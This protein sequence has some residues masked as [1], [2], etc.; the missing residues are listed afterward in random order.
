MQ[1]KRS[2]SCFMNSPESHDSVFNHNNYPNNDENIEYGYRYRY[3]DL[4]Y[5]NNHQNITSEN[6]DKN[7]FFTENN[8]KN[9]ERF[10]ILKPNIFYTHKKSVF[11][12]VIRKNQATFKN[13]SHNSDYLQ[14]NND[15]EKKKLSSKDINRLLNI[16]IKLDSSKLTKN[17]D[18]AI[19]K[20]NEILKKGDFTIKKLFNVETFLLKFLKGEEINND[21]ISELN[22]IEKVLITAFLVKKK[23]LDVDF[24]EFNTKSI[25]FIQERGCHKRSEQEY[26]T[27]LKKAFKQMI[28]IFNQK[29]LIF[30][31]NKKHFYKHYFGEI[32][33][34]LNIPI[35]N[36][37]LEYLFNE[38]KNQSKKRKS[39]KNYA[40]ILKTSSKFMNDLNDYLDNSF[41]YNGKN[42]GSIDDATKDIN[43][44][45]PGIVMKWKNDLM[46][47][48]D[49]D[50]ISKFL[51]EFFKNKKIKL[52]WSFTEISKAIIS[53]KELM[54]LK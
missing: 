29:N 44:K 41:K 33:D 10:Q 8:H 19:M 20:I 38:K 15:E 54:L 52:P 46:K 23:Y 35:E 43:K 12:P 37:E 24:L 18:E 31:S 7:I 16:F 32:L 25:K 27:V 45:V 42:F 36:I 9:D 21:M 48:D 50:S 14:N 39:K 28:Y 40:Q 26:K 34:Q 17:N 47:N 11:Q 2:Y 6:K 4:F 22:D 30:D 49:S 53:V 13:P 5:L 3:P 51:I 1:N